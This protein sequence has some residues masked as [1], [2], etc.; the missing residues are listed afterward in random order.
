MPFSVFQANRRQSGVIPSL[1]SRFAIF[2]DRF[3]N[4]PRAIRV[5]EFEGRLS[6]RTSLYW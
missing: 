1:W 6:R 5:V 4:L 2:A 3:S